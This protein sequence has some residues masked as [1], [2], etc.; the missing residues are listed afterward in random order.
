MGQEANSTSV[1]FMSSSSL[2]AAL[3]V[4][5]SQHRMRFVIADNRVCI[6]NIASCKDE[7]ANVQKSGPVGASFYCLV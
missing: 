2:L 5:L 3:M 4:T 6:P 1:S 7:T